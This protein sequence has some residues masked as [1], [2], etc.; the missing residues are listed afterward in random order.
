MN[1]FKNKKTATEI[2]IDEQNKKNLKDSNYQVNFPIYNTTTNNQCP[3]GNPSCI[4]TSA[5]LYICRLCGDEFRYKNIN[6]SIRNICDNCQLLSETEILKLLIPP[7]SRIH[8]FKC[9]SHIK[10][11]KCENN[12]AIDDLKK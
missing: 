1:L 4:V 5:Y 2:S 10:A 9:Y 7:D 3:C 8:C 6:Y 11:C 12:K